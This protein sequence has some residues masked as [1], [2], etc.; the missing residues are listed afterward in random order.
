MSTYD[1]HLDRA[2]EAAAPADLV[3]CVDCGAVLHPDDAI[4]DYDDGG[5]DLCESCWDGR[6][7]AAE[8]AAEA[9]HCLSGG[10]APCE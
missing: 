2:I 10:G 5:D 3:E 1:A 7:W 6:E 4:R 9:A 8:A